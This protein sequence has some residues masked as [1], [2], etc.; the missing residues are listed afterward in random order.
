LSYNPVF[1]LVTLVFVLMPVVSVVLNYSG[2]DLSDDRSGIAHGEGLFDRLQSRSVVFTVSD[3]DTFSL[4]YLSLVERPE[5]D[6]AVVAS[7]LLRFE[8]YAESL[9]ETYGDRIPDV[10]TQDIE[11]DVAA[12][13]A[14]NFE[15]GE[16][17]STYTSEGLLKMFQLI[18]ADNIYIIAPR[19]P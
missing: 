11:A 7:P 5:R 15:G 6:I 4:W 17:Y 9:K 18:Q 2:Q 1:F 14:L 13:A 3:A 8:W 16:V 19:A 12:I 10:L